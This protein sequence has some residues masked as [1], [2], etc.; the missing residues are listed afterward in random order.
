[1]TVGAGAAQGDETILP[2]NFPGVVLDPV[3]F[4]L[5]RNQKM[6]IGQ[7]EELGDVDTFEKNA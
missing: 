4:D 1:V 3:H 5:T 2:L 6:A 7:F